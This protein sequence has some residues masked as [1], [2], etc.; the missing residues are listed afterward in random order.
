MSAPSQAQKILLLPRDPGPIPNFPSSPIIAQFCLLVRSPFSG[1]ICF[2]FVLTFYLITPV[3]FLTGE[4][5]RCSLPLLLSMYLHTVSG[6]LWKGAV[7]WMPG[8]WGSEY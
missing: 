4:A 6:E 1:S 7:E 2:T 3:C 5:L 8:C